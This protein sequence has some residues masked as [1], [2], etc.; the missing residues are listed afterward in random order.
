M[1]PATCNP[2]PG[3]KP[4]PP[5]NWILLGTEVSASMAAFAVAGWWLS[6]RYHSQLPLVVLCLTGVGVAF[7]RL[8]RAAARP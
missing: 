3:R 1:A 7:W 2:E 5:R 4:D 6:E 8:L